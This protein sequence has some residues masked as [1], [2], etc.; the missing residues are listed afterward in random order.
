M[1]SPEVVEV[2]LVQCNLVNI[3]YQQKP[4]VLYTF[5]PN[6]SNFYQLNVESSNLVFLTTFNTKF[7]YITTTYINQNGRP[8]E[9]EDKIVY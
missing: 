7:D 5:R 1:L 8:L 9:I 6:K 2:V 4:D 3:Q